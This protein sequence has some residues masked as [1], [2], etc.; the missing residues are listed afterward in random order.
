MLA[1]RCGAGV[2]LLLAQGMARAEGPMS[3]LGEVILVIFGV[4]SVVWCIVAGIVFALA[5]KRP[6]GERIAVTACVFLAPYAAL[7]LFVGN[8]I[9]STA[10]RG[11]QVEYAKTSVIL[12]GVTFPPGSEVHYRREPGAERRLV[13]AS[14]GEVLAL[15]VLRI[16]QLSVD[17]FGP[18]YLKVSL[19]A[20]QEIDGWRCGGFGDVYLR[21]VGDQLTL[22]SCDLEGV[23][24]D[25]IAWPAGSELANLGPGK[26]F[27]AWRPDP[28]PGVSDCERTVAAFGLRLQKVTVELDANRR[29]TSFYGTS[30]DT[31][32]TLGGYIIPPFATVE[33]QSDGSL[34]VINRLNETESAGVVGCLRLDRRGK[35]KPCAG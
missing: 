12:G 31:T 25:G 8:N 9:A 13:A 10:G 7:A 23:A 33:T 29:M 21:R 17:G 6:K 32:Q 4:F 27:L 14:T 24:I 26:W 30:C 1:A 35:V 22:Q 34:R 2:F 19:A 5:R 20:P 3:G 11:I 15:G 16:K 28:R 18:D